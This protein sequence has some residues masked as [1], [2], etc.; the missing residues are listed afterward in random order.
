MTLTALITDISY[1]VSGYEAMQGY[2]TMP[3]NNAIAP[4]G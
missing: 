1:S 3:V 2:E 4:N